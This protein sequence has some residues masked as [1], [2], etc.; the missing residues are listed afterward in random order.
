MIATDMGSGLSTSFVYTGS[1]GTNNLITTIM[2][3]AAV[4]GAFPMVEIGDVYYGDGGVVVTNDVYNAVQ[5][6]RDQ[7]F[8]SGAIQVDTVGVAG[9]LQPQLTYAQAQALYVLSPNAVANV[10]QRVSIIQAIDSIMA[11]IDFYREAQ[12]GLFRLN[13]FPSSPLPGTGLE[14]NATQ[15]QQMVAAGLV[16]GQGAFTAAAADAQSA[17]PASC[18]IKTTTVPCGHDKDCFNFAVEKCASKLSKATCAHDTRTC[19]LSE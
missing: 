12:P 16:V 6:C 8:S 13:L 19:V 9:A 2:A 1:V 14:F 18:T 4:P 3:S 10:G 17:L 11:V 15:M 7:G 5:L